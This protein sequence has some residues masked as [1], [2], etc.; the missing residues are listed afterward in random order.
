MLGKKC[1]QKT[2]HFKEKQRSKL[3]FWQ[4]KI[5]ITN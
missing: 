3:E 4:G 1:I 2:L 5:N